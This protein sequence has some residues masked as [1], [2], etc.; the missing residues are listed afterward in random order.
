MPGIPG[1]HFSRVC[2]ASC[3]Q[4]STGIYRRHALDSRYGVSFVHLPVAAGELPT[5]RE[6]G[7]V[8][9]RGS[10]VCEYVTATLTWWCSE[11]PAS[12]GLMVTVLPIY[13]PP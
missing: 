12:A 8:R 9:A 3:L 13:R 5:H 10:L 1:L 11:M 6:M 4:Q 2:Q 7:N